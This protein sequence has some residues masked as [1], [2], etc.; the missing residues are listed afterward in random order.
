MRL[1][2]NLPKLVQSPSLELLRDIK[3][4]FLSF[5]SLKVSS[6]HLISLIETLI[7]Y[8]LLG[9]TYSICFYSIFSL[10]VASGL[11]LGVFSSY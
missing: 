4:S 5:D 1:L 8:F 11:S 7:L 2:L 3:V 10:L 6:V 9:Y